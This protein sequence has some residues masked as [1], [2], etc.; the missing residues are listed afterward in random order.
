MHCI[1]V[2]IPPRCRILR[3]DC[4]ATEAGIPPNQPAA[5]LRRIWPLTSGVL[6]H[7]RSPRPTTELIAWDVPTCASDARPQAVQQCAVLVSLCANESSLAFSRSV[8]SM[9]CNGTKVR[10][11]SDGATRATAKTA[12]VFDVFPGMEESDASLR[13]STACLS[14]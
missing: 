5:A 10:Y 14:Q 1:H 3:R 4:N 13:R 12:K 8:W 7:A 9:L 6:L 11:A 2:T